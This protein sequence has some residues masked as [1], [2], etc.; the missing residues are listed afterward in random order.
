VYAASQ[1]PSVSQAGSRKINLLRHTAGGFSLSS[2]KHHD[3]AESS[4]ETNTVLVV[5]INRNAV[6]VQRSEARACDL[7]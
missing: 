5:N 4:A 6:V 3:Y 2:R 1:S 7:S